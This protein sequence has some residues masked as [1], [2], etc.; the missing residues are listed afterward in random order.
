ME[1]VYGGEVVAKG[2]LSTQTT[3]H[4][5]VVESHE[6][7]VMLTET[8][9]TSPPPGYSEDAFCVGSFVKWPKESVHLQGV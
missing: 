9:T 4:G 6:T 3:V 7:A 5:Q 1:L 8:F 2:T